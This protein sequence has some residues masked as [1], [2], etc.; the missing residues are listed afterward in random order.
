M[1]KTFFLVGGFWGFFRREYGRTLESRDDSEKMSD[2]IVSVNGLPDEF[3][4]P[5]EVRSVRRYF[6]KQCQRHVSEWEME[7]KEGCYFHDLKQEETKKVIWFSGIF[8]AYPEVLVKKPWIT[9]PYRIWFN[10]ENGM[11]KFR[12][13]WRYIDRNWPATMTLV[14]PVPFGNKQSVYIENENDIPLI[15]ILKYKV[16]LDEQKEKVEAQEAVKLEE[17]AKEPPAPGS[18][19]GELPYTSDFKC[20]TCGKQLSGLTG[21]VAHCRLAHKKAV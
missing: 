4:K 9:D 12:E 1:K 14:L 21:A 15:D 7:R 11:E 2:W 5:A 20:R 19:P 18:A 10:N 16:I 8:E 13:I 3:F 6:C 17:L